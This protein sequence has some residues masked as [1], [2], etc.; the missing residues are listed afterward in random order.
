MDL[1]LDCTWEND[2]VVT[3]A[4]P[5]LALVPEDRVTMRVLDGVPEP[6]ADLGAEPVVTRPQSYVGAIPREHDDVRARRHEELVGAWAALA[7]KAEIDTWDASISAAAGTLSER[8][9]EVSEACAFLARVGD[10]ATE[11]SLADL[12]P[13]DAPLTAYIAGVYLWLGE[14][15]GA[16]D[17]L[18]LQ[19]AEMTPNWSELRSRLE[20]VEWILDLAEREREKARATQLGWLPEH[21]ESDVL[22]LFTAVGAL[23]AGL[24]QKFG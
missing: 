1:A 6:V 9:A 8:V 23:R 5:S 2:T 12:L 22:H 19:L 7:Q 24:D 16:L 20:D 15:V 13:D 21:V 3:R 17:S 11:T 18:A 10:H 14:V 4:A